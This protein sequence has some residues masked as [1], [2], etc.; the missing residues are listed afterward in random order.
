MLRIGW[1]SR[2]ITP[3]RPAMI[4]GQMHRRI[5]HDAAD[6][7]TLTA[8][9][10][11][12]GAGRAVLVSCDLTMVTSTLQ[13]LVAER[14]R[15][16]VPE[17]AAG[18]VVL[19]ATHTHESLVINDGFYEQPEG[20]MTPAE[21]TEW[22]AGRAV[23]A[24]VEA[25]HGRRPARVGRAHGHA[26]VGHNRRAAYA[27]GHVAMY[28]ATADPAFRHIEG[29][30]DHGLDLLFMWGDGGQLEGLI[31]DLPCPAQV[32]E[33]LER[34]SAD[35]WH[36][37]RIEL[38][39][40]LGAGLAILPL[41]GAAGDLSPHPLL[42]RRLDQEMRARRGITQRQEIAL[43][44]ADAVERA[45]AWTAPAPGPCPV[46]GTS[47]HLAL[48]R[49]RIT[50]AERDWSVAHLGA[51]QRQDGWW[52]RN[53]RAVV[54]A[55]D[56][57]GLMPLVAVDLHVLR[58]GDAVIATNPFE[59]YLDYGE[60]IKA[61]SAAAQTLVVQLA[62]GAEIYLPSARAALAGSYGAHPV[63]AAVGPEGG[64]AVVEATVAAIATLFPGA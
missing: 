37:I 10:I 34:F 20:V 38:R 24:A 49:R 28:G 16:L 52:P 63:V 54:A 47:V 46:A 41:C 12:D 61:R 58:L 64:D 17:L 56:Q 1:A 50:R 2:D 4:M 22:V 48:P 8:C 44:V 39:K 5:G 55:F 51:D 31:L 3:T 42:H 29:G 11:D 33:Q 53:H 9:A 62:A 35:F 36:E 15:R 57:D 21:G 14:V 45:L 40:R 26:V 6:P 27:D 13:A 19:N 43:R 59:L 7:L 30:E 23:A 32:D 60:R 25:W 18:L